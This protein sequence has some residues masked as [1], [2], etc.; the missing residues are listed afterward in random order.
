MPH[1]RFRAVDNN[2]LKTI[3]VKLLDELQPIM[4]SPRNH[5]TLESIPTTFIFD[6]EEV[7][8]YPFIEV[9]WFERGQETRDRVAKVITD[10][11]RDHVEESLDIAVVFTA[12]NP[13]A[14]Y[15]NGIHY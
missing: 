9:L 11:L 6:G 12:L 4:N 10:C 7:S 13:D 8:A 3:S 14:Y 2:I 1:I 15:D 5:F